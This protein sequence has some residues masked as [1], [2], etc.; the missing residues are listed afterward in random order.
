MIDNI[1]YLVVILIMGMFAFASAYGF[2]LS[3]CVLISRW[4]AVSTI[5]K[6]HYITILILFVA[7]LNFICGMGIVETLIMG[8][9]AGHGK[10]EQG[11]YYLGEVV[12]TPV[13]SSTFLICKYYEIAVLSTFVL[14]SI[15][16]C[17]TFYMQEEPK[18]TISLKVIK[19]II[20]KRKN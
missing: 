17:I 5:K 18:E 1:E 14:S 3:V 7:A 20:K 19:E 11:Q 10:F 13:S 4:H 9:T 15:A 8:G 16:A 2:I 12:Y 6:L